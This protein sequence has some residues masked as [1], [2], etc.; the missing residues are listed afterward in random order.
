MERFLDRYH[1][2]FS[3]F[4]DW[5]YQLVIINLIAILM[6]V[7]GLGVFGFFPALMTTYALI[8]RRLNQEDYP[9]FKTFIQ[10]FKA[11]FFKA[12]LL[13]YIL[14]AIWTIIVL[15]WMFY[16][17]D[18]D[19]LFHWIGLFIM[20]FVAISAFLV[21]TYMPVSFVYFPKFSTYEHLKFSLLMALGMPKVTLIIALNTLFF[22]GFILI[23]LVTIFPFLAFSLPAFVNLVVARKKLLDVFTFF[24]DEHIRA[25]SLN[26]YS[27]SLD[28]WSLYQD[29]LETI[30]PI[31]YDDFMSQGLEN[32]MLDRRLSMALIDQK[33][34][35]IGFM[36]VLKNGL[37]AHLMM[38]YIDEAYRRRGYG[39]RMLLGFE[40]K[41][42]SYGFDHITIGHSNGFYETLPNVFARHLPFFRKHGYEV[43]Q[44]DAGYVVSKN[45]E[46]K[47]Q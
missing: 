32:P 42:F 28:I 45:I 40:K 9:I 37:D 13:G 2:K 11:Y 46:V 6:T 25:L 35:L 22:Y 10:T 19:S 5:V 12:N 16:L 29:R 14:V 34:A 36:I 31:T 39:K 7:I 24:K 43:K 47:E 27:K 26:A 15:S 17:N 4:T 1:S 18:L 38:I 30:W 21:T 20:G 41:A 3:K 8:K 44:T 33:E 23:R